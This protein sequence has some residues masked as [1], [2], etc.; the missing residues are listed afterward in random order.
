MRIVRMLAPLLVLV[1]APTFAQ[2]PAVSPATPAAPA[3]APAADPANIL[4]LDLSTGGRVSVLLRP[5]K[6]PASVERI[7]LLVKRGF[8]NGLIFHRVIEGFMAQGGDPK[9]DGS[10]G[11]DLPD[12]KAEFNDMPHVRG[13]MSMARAE[14]PD[15]AN[16]QFFLMLAPNLQLDGKYTA[17]G[18]VISG[19]G[20]VDLIERGEPPANPSRIIRA[21]FAS[22]NVPP[23]PPSAARASDAASAAADAASQQAV[24][25]AMASESAARAASSGD[26]ATASERAQAA[27]VSADGAARAAG[28]AAEVLAAP[29]ATKPAPK[30]RR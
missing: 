28:D 13:E 8:Y 23:P 22:D 27:K 19:M 14:S 7:R 1:A 15:S 29:P 4:N 30:R 25:A 26:K 21:S 9:G 11:S 18:R 24:D 10:G 5:D 12:L 16:S 6:A 2:K 3:P 17:V 20:Y